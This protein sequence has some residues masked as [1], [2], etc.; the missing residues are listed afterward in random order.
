M[1]HIKVQSFYIQLNVLQ[2]I[3][4][5]KKKQYKGTIFMKLPSKQIISK[6]AVFDQFPYTFK[7]VLVGKLKFFKSLNFLLYLF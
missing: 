5:L 4:Q 3:S 7:K 1:S 6:F 2:Y